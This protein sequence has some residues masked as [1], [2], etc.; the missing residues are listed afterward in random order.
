VIDVEDLPPSLSSGIE[1]A[2]STA[3]PGTLQSLE[4]G[5]ILEALRECKG[6]KKKA[7]RNLG[8]H[9]STL[10]AKLRRYGLF[11]APAADETASREERQVVSEEATALVSS[12][13]E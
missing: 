12:S 1:R 3:V 10:Y 5:R 11:D 9:R 2:R 7:A 6:N 8:I 13:R 4:R